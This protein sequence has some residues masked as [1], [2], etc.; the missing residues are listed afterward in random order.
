MES[1]KAELE[2]QSWVDD[3]CRKLTG[4]SRDGEG[5]QFKA[6][7]CHTGDWEVAGFNSPGG[8]AQMVMGLGLPK[9]Q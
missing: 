3:V 5:G 6:V 8:K 4:Q 1:V 9:E 7:V 2:R